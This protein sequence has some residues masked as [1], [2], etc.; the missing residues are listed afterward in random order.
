MVVEQCGAFPGKFTGQERALVFVCVCCARSQ[1]PDFPPEA[2]TERQALNAQLFNEALG[3]KAANPLDKKTWHVLNA[4]A[5]HDMS[6]MRELLGMPIKCLAATRN[7]AGFF[8]SVIF[9]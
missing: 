7:P 6:V 2:G 4:L 9:Q 3:P 5:T 8:T 1:R